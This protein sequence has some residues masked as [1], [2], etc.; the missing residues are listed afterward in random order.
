MI[1]KS[2]SRKKHT[3]SLIEN[4]MKT[5]FFFLCLISLLFS[6]EAAAKNTAASGHLRSSKVSAGSGRGNQQ[7]EHND[8]VPVVSTIN[9]MISSSMLLV[10]HS[11]FQLKLISIWL[12]QHSKDTG[13][14]S[15]THQVEDGDRH[16]GPAGYDYDRQCYSCW[17][18]SQLGWITQCCTTYP[19]GRYAPHVRC[20]YYYC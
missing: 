6:W 18:S 9:A 12:P 11:Y 19:W 4:I 8:N 20:E 17:Y 10:Q 15:T 3:S 13:S 5:F 1:F 2:N 7:N 14:N 16:L